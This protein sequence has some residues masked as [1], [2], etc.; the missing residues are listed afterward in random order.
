MF[1][2]V[3][4]V[5][6]YE[7]L[8]LYAVQINEWI[9]T[10]DVKT[11]D[12]ALAQAIFCFFSLARSLTCL[13]DCGNSY[14]SVSS[15]RLRYLSI[16][17]I[18]CAILFL[19]SLHFSRFFLDRPSVRSF[20]RLW[21]RTRLFVMLDLVIIIPCTNR[22]RFTSACMCLDL[23]NCRIIIVKYQKKKTQNDVNEQIA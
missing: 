20:V 4:I 11:C 9:V 1:G 18:L 12:F 15:L 17:F 8:W 7:G 3:V 23:N 22:G 19:A 13:L 16:Q 10:G 6:F 2:Q 5:I 21:F 14:F